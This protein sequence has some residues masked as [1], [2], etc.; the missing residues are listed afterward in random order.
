M[1]VNN[2]LGYSVDTVRDLMIRDGPKGLARCD[3][4]RPIAAIDVGSQGEA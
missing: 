3:R 2:L 4:L 1:G